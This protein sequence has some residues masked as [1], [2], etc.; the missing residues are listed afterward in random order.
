ML[1]VQIVL[2]FFM[3]TNECGVL[4]KVDLS[5]MN[6]ED[7]NTHTMALD[8]MTP[9]EIAA[10]MNREDAGVADAVSK[11]LPQIA[12]AITWCTA[13]L[14]K[15]G[16]IIY[17]GAGTSGRLGLLDAVECPPTFG[18]PPEMVIGLIA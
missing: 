13:A 17:M 12:E 11:V 16:R 8:T 10:A 5:K 6:T 15:H 18:V 1:Y 9:L 3:Y 4:K 7:R 14:K 2:P